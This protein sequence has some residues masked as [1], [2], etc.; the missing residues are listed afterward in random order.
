MPRVVALER[1]EGS[2]VLVLGAA[3]FIGSHLTDRLI[4][5]GADVVGIDN[6]STSDGSNLSHLSGHDS[7][8]FIEAKLDS[9]W[10]RAPLLSSR[11]RTRPYVSAATRRP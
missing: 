9:T 6:L 2:T 10:I 7:F 3:G 8:T 1:L 11:A 5:L 4:S